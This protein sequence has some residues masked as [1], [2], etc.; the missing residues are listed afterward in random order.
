MNQWRRFQFFEERP[1]S[2]GLSEDLRRSISCSTG[3]R[4]AICL[5]H[6]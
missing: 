3:G 2:S 1:A 4:G 5:G 6:G